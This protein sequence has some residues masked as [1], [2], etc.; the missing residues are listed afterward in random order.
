[1]MNC[2]I[3]LEKIKG[4]NNVAISS[5]CALK[6]ANEDAM[7]AGRCLLVVLLIRLRVALLVR[8][9]AAGATT[10][11]LDAVARPGDAVP[12]TGAIA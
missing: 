9:S 8:V 2:C 12:F 10:I 11:E 7:P 3:P 4:K 1:M 5:Q 6:L